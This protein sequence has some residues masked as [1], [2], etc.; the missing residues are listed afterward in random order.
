MQILGALVGFLIGSYLADYVG[1]KGT[2]VWSAVASF[3]MVLLFLLVPMD[4]TALF[5]LGIPLNIVLL[6]KFP[7]MG[8]FMTELYPTEIRGTGQSFCYNAGRAAG[9]LFPT[10]VGY[11]SQV[12]SLGIT[13]AICSATAFG[14][15]IVMLLLLPETHGRSLATLETAAAGGRSLSHAY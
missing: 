5:W 7:P 3:V 12:Q 4:N 14:L 13:I 9:S 8:P 1:R 10:M 15:M 2:F 6:M 11:L